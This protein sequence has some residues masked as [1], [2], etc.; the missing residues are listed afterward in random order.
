MTFVDGALSVEEL[1]QFAE[2]E[3][4]Y[5]LVNLGGAG[6]KRTT[7]R[8]PLADLQDMG[9]DA[10]LFALNCMRAA[11]NGLWDYLVDLRARGSEA[12]LDFIASMRGTPFES[13][14]D[15]TGYAKVRELEEKYLP[16]EEV[17]RRYAMA[18]EG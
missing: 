16:L 17:E 12:D 14:Y 15:Y 9:Y 18:Q 3:C 8:P 7:P 1:K 5:R 6:K 4:R 2:V 10:A 13:W 11:V